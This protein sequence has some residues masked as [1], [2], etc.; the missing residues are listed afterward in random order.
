MRTLRSVFH[1]NM[2]MGL[3]SLLKKW[4]REEI[5]EKTHKMPRK[6]RDE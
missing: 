3:S 6:A 2:E 5:S 1:A 4:Q